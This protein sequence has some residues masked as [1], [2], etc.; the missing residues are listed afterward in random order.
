MVGGG[1]LL[2]QSVVLVA[3]AKMMPGRT[4]SRVRLAVEV[5]RTAAVIR[6]RLKASDDV[7]DVLV[8]VR[9]APRAVSRPWSPEDPVRLAVATRRTLALLPGD[10]RCLVQS[11]TLSAMLGRRGIRSMLVLGT[12]SPSTSGLA[13]AWVEDTSGRPLLPVRGFLRLAEL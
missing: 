6:R 11:L 5:V 1:R 10:S 12:R 3:T 13:H 2:G 7:R 8:D 9:D 4:R